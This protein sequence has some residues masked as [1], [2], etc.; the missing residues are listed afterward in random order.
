M[1]NLQTQDQGKSSGDLEMVERKMKEYVV[2]WHGMDTQKI[3]EFIEAKTLRGAIKQMRQSSN[4]KRFR[5]RH[6][7]FAIT[8]NQEVDYL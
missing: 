5:Q 6:P 8:L 2:I 1:P 4:I 3:L 7:Y